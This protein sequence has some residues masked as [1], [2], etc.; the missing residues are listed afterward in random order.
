MPGAPIVA[1][2]SWGVPNN[3][4]GCP[5]CSSQIEVNLTDTSLIEELTK[6]QTE[7]VRSQRLVTRSGCE[8]D[9]AFAPDRVMSLHRGTQHTVTAI[10]VISSHM[11]CYER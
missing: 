9:P 4:C 2:F 5:L 11:S 7:N 1:S 8:E 10:W 6:P 3:S